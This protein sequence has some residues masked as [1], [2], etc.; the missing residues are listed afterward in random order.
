M[1]ISMGI[2]MA[3]ASL[4]SQFALPIAIPV[5]NLSIPFVISQAVGDGERR[6]LDTVEDDYF[7][8]AEVDLWWRNVTVSP[9]LERLERL[10][11]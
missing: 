1:G 8:S 2:S 11:A 3:K 9:R 6:T 10:E 7:L 5:S 4:L